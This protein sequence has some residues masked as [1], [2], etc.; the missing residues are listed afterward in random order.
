MN[1]PLDAL[2]R[3]QHIAE[4][5]DRLNGPGLDAETRQKMIQLR[6]QLIEQHAELSLAE[7][8]EAADAAAVEIQDRSRSREAIDSAIGRLAAGTISAKEY[9]EYIRMGIDL[10]PAPAEAPDGQIAAV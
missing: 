10:P 9:Q 8:Q 5:M 1:N 4:L 6:L 7:N 2:Q 3:Q